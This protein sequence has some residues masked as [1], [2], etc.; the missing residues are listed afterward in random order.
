MT[1]L[2]PDLDLEIQAL[3][4]NI[5]A[6]PEYFISRNQVIGLITLIRKGLTDPQDRQARIDILRL[7]VGEYMEEVYGVRVRSTNNLAGQA[8]SKLIDLLKEDWDGIPETDPWEL[9][10]TGQRILTLAEE[11]VKAKVIT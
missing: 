10:P 1:G 3:N 8:A 7:F 9:S 5:R 11:H 2:H 4:M 6:E